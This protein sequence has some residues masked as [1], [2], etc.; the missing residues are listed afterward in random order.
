M[1][2]TRSKKVLLVAPHVFPDQLLVGYGNVKH[3]SAIATI[4]P[5]IH[6]LKPDVIFFDHTHMGADLEKTLRRLQTNSAYKSIKICLYKKEEAITADSIFKILGVHHII[7]SHD[8]QKASKAS[9]A[10]NAIN[11]MIDASLIRLVAGA[12]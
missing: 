12:N 8:L 10:L 4:F 11:N 6:S 9:A 5:N 1:I 7:Y 3:V 2:R